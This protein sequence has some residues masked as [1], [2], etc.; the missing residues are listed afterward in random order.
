MPLE[1]IPIS[2]VIFGKVHLDS[3]NVVNDELDIFV[4][5]KIFSV[6]NSKTTLDMIESQESIYV[7]I[8]I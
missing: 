1:G 2:D 8:V 6:T 4:V 7:V 3:L 5:Y